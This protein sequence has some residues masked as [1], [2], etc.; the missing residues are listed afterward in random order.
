MRRVADLALLV[1]NLKIRDLAEGDRRRADVF[2]RFGR[3]DLRSP[4]YV[5]TLHGKL[6]SAGRHLRPVVNRFFGHDSVRPIVGETR[7]G[8]DR[9]EAP[10]KE[11]ANLS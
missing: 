4:W 7:A 11:P 8:P 10:L 1:E 5:R 2:A 6:R 9:T 3:R